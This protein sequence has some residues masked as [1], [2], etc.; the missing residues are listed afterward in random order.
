[1]DPAADY[2]QDGYSNHQ[3]YAFGGNMIMADV[4]RHLPRLVELGDDSYIE[5][6]IDT[7]REDLAYTPQ[8][9]SDLENW[10]DAQLVTLDRS[11]GDVEIYRIPVASGPG[12]RNLFYR[13][14]AK[15]K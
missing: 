3:E 8:Q 14:V 4:P 15:A 13:V 9:S 2:D 7:S 11:E 1:M 12:R 10:V 6:G 5:F